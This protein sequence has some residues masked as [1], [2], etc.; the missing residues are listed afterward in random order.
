VKIPPTE[1]PAGPVTE[2]GAA[3]RFPLPPVLFAAPLAAALAADRRM[4]RLPLPGAGTAGLIRAGIAVTA[5][6]V[7][8]SAAGVVTVLRHRTTVVPHHP[9]NRLVTSGPY[10][11]SRN[12]MYTGHA[13]AVVGVGLWTGSWWPIG[14]ALLSMLTTTHLVIA[15]E[16]E[17]LGRRFG[18]EYTRYRSQVRRWL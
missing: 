4:W 11:I 12:P 8:L 15:P 7:A 5:A 18:A 2:A 3:V 13:V 17:Y 1:P 10:R 14:A 6:G 16:E 9:V